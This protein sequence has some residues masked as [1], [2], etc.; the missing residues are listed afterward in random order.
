MHD[1]CAAF[2]E[3]LQLDRN[4]DWTHCGAELTLTTMFRCLTTLVLTGVLLV[5]PFLCQTDACCAGTDAAANDAVASQ[6][7]QTQ[8]CCT[9]CDAGLDASANENAVAHHHESPCKPSERCADPCL[10]NGAV[11]S[12]T[13]V[14]AL[15]DDSNLPAPLPS[16]ATASQSC[17][18]VGSLSP[19]TG[20]P[21]LPG[22]DIRH[23]RMSLL[24]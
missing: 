14:T 13:D 19:A 10:C 17:V 3:E 9:H 7:V 21:P 16:R 12:S 1:S 11:L 24:I 6:S 23:A 8:S 18:A 15:P 20:P 22:R 4:T 5:C 2:T